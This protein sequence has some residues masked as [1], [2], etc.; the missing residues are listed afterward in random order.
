MTLL[1][2][3]LLLA[4]GELHAQKNQGFQKVQI[5]QAD[6]QLR[7]QSQPD[8]QRLLGNV[9]LGFNEARLYCDS[10][11]KYDS[12]EFKALGN[13]R[14]QDGQQELLASQLSLNPK[15]QRALAE[16]VDEFPVRMTAQAGELTAPLLV[17]FLNSKTVVFPK[18]G[19]LLKE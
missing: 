4:F 11:W 13:V 3:L 8:I 18:G 15:E 14:L 6:L 16:T 9:V 10:A 12:G 7:D 17:Y 2:G 1:Q 19:E 5:I